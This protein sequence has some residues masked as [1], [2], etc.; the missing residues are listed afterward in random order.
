MAGTG[1]AAAPGMLKV[2]AGDLRDDGI[3]NLARLEVQRKLERC[4][5]GVELLILDNLA[6]L[7]AGQHENDADGW[8]AVQ[9][10]LLRL[11]RRGISVVVVHHAGKNGEQRGIS[12][13]EDLLDTSISLRRPS[14][15]SPAEGARFEVHVAKGRGLRGAPALPFEASLA[16]EADKAVWT[17]RPIEDVESARVEALLADGMS[18][19]DIAE[20]TG[21]ARSTVHRLKKKLERDT[22]TGPDG[23]V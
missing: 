10:W 7:L 9:Q 21:I 11:R 15:Y 5:D 22:K 23:T 14:D 17:V 19:R 13:R 2:L 1:V 16:T 6:S 12:N 18:I 3:G 8:M 20:E 4:L